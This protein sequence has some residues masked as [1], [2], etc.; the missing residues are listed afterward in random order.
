MTRYTR[1]SP[2]MDPNVFR[3]SSHSHYN[4][5]RDSLSPRQATTDLS[6]SLHQDRYFRE[7]SDKQD[8]HHFDSYLAPDYGSDRRHHDRLT[9]SGRDID[10]LVRRYA[11]FE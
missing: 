6:S 8:G 2:F 10:D 5:R 3:S 1:L 4:T 7:H 11:R 9:S